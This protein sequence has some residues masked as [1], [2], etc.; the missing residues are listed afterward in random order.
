M[1]LMERSLDIG[2][3]NPGL[4]YDGPWLVLYP[5]EPPEHPPWAH[6]VALVIVVLIVLCPV[7]CCCG[8]ACYR[9][10][11]QREERAR[12]LAH[13]RWLASL[14]VDE[15]AAYDTEQSDAWQRREREREEEERARFVER[16]RWAG[17]SA[18]DDG[19]YQDELYRG[20]D[21]ARRQDEESRRRE[22]ASR[23]LER[24]H[25]EARALQERLMAD[26]RRN[27]C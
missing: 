24:R 20:A 16:Q 13:A 11:L 25:A 14:S 2:G 7:C 5:G 19:R 3:Q 8:C 6:A 12:E 22:E 17:V 10:R 4:E 23:D 27:N 1:R 15:R 9:L 21:E 18:G 26:A